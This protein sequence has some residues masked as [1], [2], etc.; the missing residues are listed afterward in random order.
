MI[1]SNW[2]KYIGLFFLSAIL[3]LLFVVIWR[4]LLLFLSVSEKSP[5]SL[6]LVIKSNTPQIT[7]L[8]YNLGEGLSEKNTVD[9]VLSGDNRFHN[10]FFPIPKQSIQG[11]R[12]DPE[13]P[14]AFLVIKKVDIVMEIARDF[15]ITVKDIDLDDLKPAHQIKEFAMQANQLTVATT[16]DADDP[17][18][19]IPVIISFDTW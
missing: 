15:N 3:I 6:R 14:T 18:I 16:D 4:S 5:F 9:S 11:F 12:F 1:Y 7:T 2:K 17:Q 13:K 10:C 19:A 8:Y